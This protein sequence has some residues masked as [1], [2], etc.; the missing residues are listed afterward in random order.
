[1]TTVKSNLVI[2][3][4]MAAALEK[5]MIDYIKLSPLAVINTD[6]Q[7]QGGDTITV[8]YYEYIG[9][10]TDLAENTAGEQAINSINKDSNSEE[11]IQSC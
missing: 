9:D 1:M 6:L 5:K 2:P 10:A 3:E 7:G 11:D 4:V 8:P